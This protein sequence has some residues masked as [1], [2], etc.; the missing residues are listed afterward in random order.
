MLTDTQKLAPELAWPVKF[1][2][3]EARALVNRRLK[4]RTDLKAT[5]YHHPFL[6]LVFQGQQHRP[7]WLSSMVRTQ[8]R[9]ELVRA[10]VLVDLVGGRAY[11]SDA[12]KTEDF[13]ALNPGD[14]PN[15]ISDPEPQVDEATAIGAARS[16]LAGVVLRRRKI[17][18]IGALELVETP[19]RLGKPNWWVTDQSDNG[20]V[21]VIVDGIT[22]KHYAFSA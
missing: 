4:Q 5:L 7:G 21:E 2:A 17:T 1:S 19:L 6:G 8:Q 18:A 16:I 14:E 12:W 20:S 3:G 10:H 22:G 11:L 13:V 9:V 15:L